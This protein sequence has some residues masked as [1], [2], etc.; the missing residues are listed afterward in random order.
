MS[1]FFRKIS[2][3][4]SV[5]RPVRQAD[6]YADQC[7]GRGKTAKNRYN[8]KQIE[9]GFCLEVTQ[10][11]NGCHNS[12]IYNCTDDLHAFFVGKISGSPF[13]CFFHTDILSSHVFSVRSPVINMIQILLCVF[14]V[15]Q[16]IRIISLCGSSW[17]GGPASFMPAP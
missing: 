12:K 10:E 1:G 16:N 2:Y 5:C 9:P 6:D 14:S 13:F 7:F 4:F 11:K 17:G 3:N 8:S 15:Q